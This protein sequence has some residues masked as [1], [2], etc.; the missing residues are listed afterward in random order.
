V[1]AS[2]IYVSRKLKLFFSRVMDGTV[3]ECCG[4][5]DNLIC[6]LS[7]LDPAIGSRTSHGLSAGCLRVSSTTRLPLRKDR[8]R[9]CP[10][11][12]QNFCLIFFKVPLNVHELLL[13]PTVRHEDNPSTAQALV[14]RLVKY[15]LFIDSPV[16]QEPAPQTVGLKAT[17]AM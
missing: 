1:A 16:T 3:L 12:S 10:Q 15:N 14:R 7:T 2:T 13:I 4:S 11:A 6:V 17:A 5:T 8:Q 9:R